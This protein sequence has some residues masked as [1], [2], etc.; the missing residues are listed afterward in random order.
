MTSPTPPLGSS[1][2]EAVDSLRG[3]SYQ[4]LR[5]IETWLDL[6]EGEV[7]VLEGAEDLD[8]IGPGGATVEQVKDTAA[9][10]NITLRSQSVLEA[11]GN[12]W[13]HQLRNP[14]Y[15]LRFRFLTTAGIGK[16]QKKPLGYDDPGLELWQ[17]IQ[18][19]PTGSDSLL[20]AAAI[21]SFLG[22]QGGLSGT[23]T[24]W[25]NRASA[26]EFVS[27]IVLPMEWV[28]GWPDWA[29]LKSTVEAKLIELCENR[30]I[31]SADALSGL[32]ALHAEVWRVATSKSTRILRR[33][34]LLR[35]V[36]ANGMTAIPNAQLLALMQTLTGSA[37]QSTT[38][39][40]A[41]EALGAAPR[42][43][44][45]RH[46]RPELEA[47]IAAALT[48]GTIQ[49]YGTTGM[50]KS[51][52]ALAVIGPTR[53][54]AWVDLRDLSPAASSKRIEEARSRL[55]QIGTAYDVVLDDLP[56]DG[57][58]RAMEGALGRLR[59]LQ[60]RT[61]AHLLVTSSG[62]LPT[63][64]A[65]QLSLDDDHVFPAPPF[66][67]EEIAAYLEA[68]GCSEGSA[69]NWS[70]IINAS[71]SGHPQL[72]DVRVA[73]LAESGF[74]KPSAA[75]LL[76]TP[77]EI[78]D[79]R[80]E[81]RRIVATRP[82]DDREL[83]ARASLLLG[84][85]PRS[86][87]MAIAQV[88]PSIAEPGN[89]I[90]RLTGPWLERTSTDDLR[91][92]PLL[93]NLG[94]DTRG[95]NWSVSMHRDIAFTFVNERVLSA[96]DVFD[97]VTHAILG[98]SASPFLP[99][100]PS[101]LQA[102]HEVWTQI[103]ETASTLTFIGIGEGLSSPFPRKVDTAAFRVLQMRIAIE[104]GK[105]E[106]IISVLEQALQEFDDLSVE[107]E[108]G[109][110]VFEVLFLWQILQ[111]PGGLPLGDRLRLGLRFIKASRKVAEAS[112]HLAITDNSETGDAE[113]LRV[114]AIVP[115]TLIPVVTDNDSLTQLLDLV[116]E[117]DPED[118]TLA[119]AGFGRDQE[120]AALALDKV[121]LGEAG[122]AEPRWQ[123][124]VDT[125][126]RAMAMASRLDVPTL[127]A[128]AATLVV[129]VIDENLDDSR[130][131]LTR[132]DTYIAGMDRP[133]RVLAAKAKVLMRC[134]RAAES[135]PLYDEAL[136]NFPLGLSWR[137]DAIRNAAVAAGRAG[138]WGLSAARFNDALGSLELHEPPV[139]RVGL[140]FDRA[141]ALH[142]TGRIRE[143]VDCLGAA[144]DLLVADGQPFPPEPLVS[145]RQMGSQVLKTIIETLRPGWAINEVSVDLH[146]VFGFA[147]ATKVLEWG[148][149]TPASL[150]HFVIVMADLDLLMPEP[151]AIAMRLVGRLRTSSE[152]VVQSGQGDTLTWLALRTLDLAS[153]ASDA[154]REMRALAFAKAEHAAGRDVRGQWVQ[155]AP[156]VLPA[157]AED[158]V[159]LRLLARAVHLLLT[160]RQDAIPLDAWR[161]D[162]QGTGGMPAVI[163]MLNDLERMVAGQ[164]NAEPRILG[165]N[166][167]WEQHLFAVLMAPIQRRVT[168]DVLLVCHVIAAR[169]LNRP[170]LK[171]FIEQPLSAMITDAWLARCDTPALLAT[172]RYSIPAIKGAVTGT[173][174][175]WPRVVAVLKAA[176]SATSS[177]AAA[178][179]RDAVR[180]LES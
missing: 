151:P 166:A 20:W 74:P 111:K 115:M 105:Q 133:S 47:S 137:T 126:D 157:G 37:S 1:Q 156:V 104:T 144:T 89:V 135:L 141:I 34:D 50:G 56:V 55:A 120:A 164:E 97:V 134:S 62:R 121:W 131:A 51:A 64:A 107:R 49:V 140:L 161:N 162:L 40:I 175:G 2:R 123:P 86:R 79:A 180:E 127:A 4:M 31:G 96:A 155:E 42:P 81:V 30:G 12:F 6:R 77:P 3:Y 143:A 125:L 14:G 85:A 17:R 128:A 9:S 102:S 28:T 169:Y 44:S 68:S 95:Q 103:A 70:K 84:R 10:G 35:L 72:V 7:L 61:G 21:Q 13:D 76:T 172:P 22:S 43:P 88:E 29:G 109:I 110:D 150:D 158:F 159:K 15:A 87:L 36:D 8:R 23:L 25:L 11:I 83:L 122:R 60:D 48:T 146:R 170:K 39:A 163:P 168:S 16:E 33:G 139:R 173:P 90:D 82:A 117:L 67:I 132:A 124:F 66:S 94:F 18:S 118:R 165:S 101:L 59:S 100:M 136:S 114:A 130:S 149:Q 176:M 119:L 179:V 112:R 148:D 73:A 93:R 65:S 98:K 153:G 27:R 147:S 80:A 92:S 45:R 178:T 58:R 108:V 54:V 154:V 41:P 171:E 152:L 52:L 26:A 129:R 71:T 99:L 106:Q 63:R 24:D 174:A 46:P 113:W 19:E 138:E 78:V 75:D 32:N 91:T 142:F 116:E 160:G 177:R 57:D 5:S 38:V 53:P 69:S 167:S 145:V